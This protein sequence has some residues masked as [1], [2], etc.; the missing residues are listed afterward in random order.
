MFDDRLT[1]AL[2]I[3]MTV[4][5]EATA[6]LIHQCSTDTEVE[7]WIVRE[8]RLDAVR[9]AQLA[10]VLREALEGMTPVGVA[11]AAVRS[12]QRCEA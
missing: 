7:A 11:R 2:L 1:R 3:L 4:G 9:A 6:V 10:P 8:T 5:P 12:R